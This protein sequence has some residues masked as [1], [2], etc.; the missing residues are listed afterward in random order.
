VRCT[1]P[2]DAVHSTSGFSAIS[3]ETRILSIE[4]KDWGK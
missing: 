1:G 3:P 4:I 2:G